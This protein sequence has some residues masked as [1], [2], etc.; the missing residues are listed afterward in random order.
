M[1][2]SHQ[3]QHI[4]K[5]YVNKLGKALAMLDGMFCHSAKVFFLSDKV[6]RG[7]LYLYLPFL[8]DNCGYVL[9]FGLF[10]WQL[11]RIFLLCYTNKCRQCRLAGNPLIYNGPDSSD[12]QLLLVDLVKLKVFSFTPILSDFTLWL[13][14]WSVQI[15]PQNLLRKM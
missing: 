4:T 2:C 3:F 13:I 12:S 1:I 8:F 11:W 7:E 10:I 5:R 6:W 9:V 15:F 14:C